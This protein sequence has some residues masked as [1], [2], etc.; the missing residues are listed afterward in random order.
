V[1]TTLT[2]DPDIIAKLKAEI[3][4]SGLSFKEAVNRFLRLGLNSKRATKSSKP[5]V[6]KAQALGVREGFNYDNI[7]DLLDQAEGP[8]HPLTKISADSP[9]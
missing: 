3:R 9:N 4:K 6:V 5:F 2:L 1:R 7:G 8:S